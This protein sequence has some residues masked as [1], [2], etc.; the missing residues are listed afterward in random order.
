MPSTPTFQLLRCC[1]VRS[2]DFGVE[3]LSTTVFKKL[4]SP[5]D[6]SGKGLWD[7]EELQTAATWGQARCPQG[8]GELELPLQ[9]PL[10]GG[11]VW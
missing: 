11:K 4:P 8:D 2:K 3:M 1:L 10:L 7:R 6:L 5:K 9:S